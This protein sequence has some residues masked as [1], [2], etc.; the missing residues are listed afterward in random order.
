MNVTV[1]IPDELVM[2]ERNMSR[3]LLIAYALEQLRLE[4]IS[5]GRLAEILDLSI[6]Q[7]Y[8]LIK[9][10]R[11]PSPYGL[12]DLERDRKTIEKLFPKC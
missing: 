2:N 8:G 11:I 1:A 9:E 5:V 10:R 6:D 7:A 4:N 3:E 12:E